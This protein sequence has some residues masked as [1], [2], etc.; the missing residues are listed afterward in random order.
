MENKN[1]ARGKHLTGQ[2]KAQNMQEK[3]MLNYKKLM[4]KLQVTV[5]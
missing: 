3:R 2:E 1:I 5:S 4:Q